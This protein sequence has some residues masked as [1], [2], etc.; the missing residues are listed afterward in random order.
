MRPRYHVTGERGWINDPNGP[1]H[2]RGTYHVFFQADPPY[3]PEGPRGWGHATSSDLVAWER[4][5]PAL[6]PEPSGPDA[7]GCW[8][9][10][11]RL[12]GGRPA[13]Y[14]TG[15]PGESVC[16]A[17][18]SD[19]LLAWERDP[20]NPLLAGPGGHHRDPFLWEDGDGWHMLLGSGDTHGRVL[21]YDSPDATAW[22]PGGVFFEAPRAAGGLDLGEVWECPQLVASGDAAALVVSCQLPGAAWPLMHAVAF[23][24]RVAGGRFE[25]RLNGRLDHGDVFYAP[26]VCRDERGR[27]LLWGWAQERLDPPDHAGAL[28]LPREVAIDKGRLVTRP[29]PE[30]EALRAEPLTPGAATPQMEL[31][32]DAGW[33]LTDGDRRLRIA[34]ERDR[35]TVAVDDGAVEPR[36]FTAPLASRARHTLRVFVDGSLVEVF[37]DDGDATITTRAHASWSRV[38]PAVGGA[39]RLRDDAVGAGRA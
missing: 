9:G 39:W 23:V 5:P 24:G 13:I 4:R 17:W 3:P 16:R 36:T 33:L 27:D 7:G 14:Y 11:T 31:T 8:S 15:I 32:G 29:V 1:I 35:L 2:H 10:C 12:I 38:E 26:A 28:T 30:L 25:G 34:V 19:D 22:S 37:A 21:R 18:G 20:A 6:T